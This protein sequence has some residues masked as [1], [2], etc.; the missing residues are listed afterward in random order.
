LK[1]ALSISPNYIGASTPFHVENEAD[2]VP[3][4]TRT[5]FKYH[6]VSPETK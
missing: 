2:S 3:K 6:T 1:I 4:I 5:F